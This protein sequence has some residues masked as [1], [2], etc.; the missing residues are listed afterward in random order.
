MKI[1][2]FAF[3]LLCVLRQSEG[4]IFGGSVLTSS[5]LRNIFLRGLNQS[6][7]QSNVTQPSGRRRCPTRPTSLRADMFVIQYLKYRSFCRIFVC[8]RAFVRPVAKE[9]IILVLSYF[10]DLTLL[11]ESPRSVGELQ[12]RGSST[13]AQ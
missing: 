2:L 11:S 10:Y 9:G 7:S 1:S 12:G 3:Y 13:P 5:K 6:Q 4:C 8:R